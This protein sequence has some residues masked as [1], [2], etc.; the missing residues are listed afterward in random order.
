M[1]DGNLDRSL[2]DGVCSTRIYPSRVYF[3]L[4][5]YEI[6]NSI[7]GRRYAIFKNLDVFTI[8]PCILRI[9]MI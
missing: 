7:L 1:R 9:G 3:I 8:V 5:Q 2:M 4:I 6:L